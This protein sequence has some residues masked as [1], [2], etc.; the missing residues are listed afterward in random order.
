[1]IKKTIILVLV[2]LLVV[3]TIYWLYMGIGVYRC[4]KEDKSFSSVVDLV[5]DST[6][7]DF[8]KEIVKEHFE[9][10][11]KITAVYGGK[12]IVVFQ[13][14]YPHAPFIILAITD[15][16]LVAVSFMIILLYKKD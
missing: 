15:A 12:M 8:K 16:V 1:M 2:I 5:K 13:D 10:K 7:I 11:E 4:I 3:N 14:T 9:R 6:D